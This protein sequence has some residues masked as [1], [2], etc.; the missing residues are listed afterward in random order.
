MNTE[1]IRT[2]KNADMKREE[3]HPSI[4]PE[5]QES[6]VVGTIGMIEKVGV[7]IVTIGSLT[8]ATKINIIKIITI[9]INT[10]GNITMTIDV[11]IIEMIIKNREIEK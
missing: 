8:D 2:A 10:K 7:G 4:F 3:N 1:E 11:N 9:K 6:P 5:I